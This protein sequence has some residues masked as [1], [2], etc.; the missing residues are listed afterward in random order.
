MN[1]TKVL[2]K[3][4]GSGHVSY[5]GSSSMESTQRPFISGCNVKEHQG[6]LR[7]YLYLL[8]VSVG[9]QQ[10]LGRKGLL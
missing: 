1:P 3:E 10:F 8:Y 9:Q 6:T 2:V 4:A 7:V 5:F